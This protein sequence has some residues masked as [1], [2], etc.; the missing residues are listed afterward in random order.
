MRGYAATDEGGPPN[1]T[2]EYR[3]AA[4][5]GGA[6]RDLPSGTEYNRK[7]IERYI[8]WPAQATAYTISM[9]KILALRQ[10]ARDRLG[11]AHDIRAFHSAKLGNGEILLGILDSVIDR[12]I[13]AGGR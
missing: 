13:D 1:V 3:R 6:R 8:A 10:R 7:S 11:G 12:R 9:Q 4:A 5:G 2:Y